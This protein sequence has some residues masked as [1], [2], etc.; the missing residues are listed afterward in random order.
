MPWKPESLSG[1]TMPSSTLTVPSSIWRRVSPGR[2]LRPAVRIDEVGVLAVGV[3]AH[4]DGERVAEARGQVVEVE[5][6]GARR[7]LVHVEKH[8]LVHEMLEHEAEGNVAAHAPRAD[9]DCLAGPDVFSVHG[10][11]ILVAQRADPRKKGARGRPHSSVLWTFCD[12]K[13]SDRW[14]R[15]PRSAAGRLPLPLPLS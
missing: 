8:D 3:V 7:L 13:V 6:L 12:G 1:P 4:A 9:D 10:A 5:R 15:S 2:R 11:P 14:R